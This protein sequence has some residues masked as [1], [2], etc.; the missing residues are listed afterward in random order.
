[1]TSNIGARELKDFGQGIGFNTLA[2]QTNSRDNNIKN[3]GWELGELLFTYSVHST[4][5]TAKKARCTAQVVQYGV[6]AI[7]WN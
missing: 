5:T 3:C 4:T 1:M 6:A 7:Y 2:K